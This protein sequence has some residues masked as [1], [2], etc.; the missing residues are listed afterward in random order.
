MWL[1]D[2]YPSG[3]PAASIHDHSVILNVSPAFVIAA[4]FFPTTAAVSNFSPLPHFVPLVEFK[5]RIDHWKWIGHGRDS[6]LELMIL[7]N[8]WFKLLDKTLVSNV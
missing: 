2:L 1:Q 8:H 4:V 3:T 7:C 5:D 6:E